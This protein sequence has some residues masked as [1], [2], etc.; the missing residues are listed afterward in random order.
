MAV[1]LKR[2]L[3]MLTTLIVLL[4]IIS[5]ISPEKKSLNN[6]VR[7][8]S[9][10]DYVKLSEGWTEYEID[11]P[12]NAPAVILIHGLSVAMY[13]WDRQYQVL[14]DEGYRVLR[15]N[16]YGRGLS[17]RPRN[18]YDSSRYVRQLKELMDA[19]DIDQAYLV[20]HS[21]G[22]LVTAAFAAEHPDKVMRQILI[23][24]ALHMA[25]NNS[26]VTLVRIPI[27]GDLMAISILPR[28]LTERAEKLFRHSG[29]SESEAY[30]NAF[31][32]QTGYR[33]FSRSVKS[34]FRN[35][36]MEDFS[37]TYARLQG[38]R[39]LLIW[40]GNDGSVP[41]KHTEKIISVLP[42]IHTAF[43]EGCGHMPNME[44]AEK[45]NSL[46]LDFLRK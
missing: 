30:V 15:Y 4:L 32:S 40:G 28:I 41:A 45:V 9:G 14:V 46:I 36:M 29:I 18:K 22:G 11:G 20:G 19:L 24:P 17:D 1:N 33:G 43:L 7:E 23:S 34:L 31:T 3:I 26:G 44:E 8:Q 2:T 16:H 38:D 37:D 27:L 42:G 13:D 25:E 21:M 12:E 35:N 6:T 39:T 5:L 10:N